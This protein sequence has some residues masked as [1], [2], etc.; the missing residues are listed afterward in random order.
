[1]RTALGVLFTLNV[2]FARRLAPHSKELSEIDFNLTPG[3]LVESSGISGSDVHHLWQILHRDGLENGSLQ[4]YAAHIESKLSSLENCATEIAAHQLPLLNSMDFG[5]RSY[6]LV[7]CSREANAA[8]WDT[9]RSLDLFFGIN[10]ACSMA[11]SEQLRAMVDSAQAGTGTPALAD[12][13]NCAGEAGNCCDSCQAMVSSNTLKDAIETI[14]GVRQNLCSEQAVLR[15]EGARDDVLSQA[16]RAKWQHR[17]QRGQSCDDP[18]DCDTNKKHKGK[19]WCYTSSAQKDW[20]IF[21]WHRPWDYCLPSVDYMSLM[22]NASNATVTK[23]QCALGFDLDSCMAIPGCVFKASLC[24]PIEFELLDTNRSFTRKSLGTRPS[25][26][27]WKEYYQHQLSLLLLQIEAGQRNYTDLIEVCSRL[28]FEY[29]LPPCTRHGLGSS[30]AFAQ[31]TPWRTTFGYC[32]LHG[33]YLAKSLKAAWA[34]KD[35]NALVEIMKIGTAEF[36]LKLFNGVPLMLCVLGFQQFYTGDIFPKAFQENFNAYINNGVL[37]VHRW[38]DDALYGVFSTLGCP[39]PSLCQGD[40]WHEVVK[41]PIVEE[42]VFRGLLQG[43]VRAVSHTAVEQVMEL[44]ERLGIFEG[45][46][47]K[48][49]VLERYVFTVTQL[50]TS[51]A[52]AYMHTWNDGG[53]VAITQSIFCFWC[54]LTQQIIHQKFGFSYAL[55]AHFI[56]NVLSRIWYALKSKIA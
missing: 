23:A 37:L 54:G 47:D 17:T 51:F 2:G 35:S 19:S 25:K 29:C 15:A 46:L 36:F 9:V 22:T 18:L 41:A 33:H 32:S 24:I 45:K 44:V 13:P 50:T 5:N 30:V 10:E 14:D 8:L 43:G 39:V 38:I 56:N 7:M 6:R 28:P 55:M 31:I 49:E 42:V 21:G 16:R 48:R 34:S 52:F 27:Q 1:M 20:G 11:T 3:F 53:P 4:V 40:D 12:I 26:A